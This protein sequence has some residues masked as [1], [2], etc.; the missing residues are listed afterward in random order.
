MNAPILAPSVKPLI[1]SFIKS[2]SNSL[3]LN[4]P[5]GAGK[6]STAEYLLSVL[7]ESNDI[8]KNPYIKI[9]DCEN[10]RGIDDIRL[11]QKDLTNKPLGNAEFKRG[12]ILNNFEN[13]SVEAQN[14]ALKLLE[15]PPLDTIFI[16]TT[17]S[18]ST[19]LPTIVS[20]LQ[21]I[22][23]KPIPREDLFKFFP[24]YKES[25]LESAYL[26]TEGYSERFSDFIKNPQNEDKKYI[27]QAKTILKDSKT[28][29]IKSIDKILKSDDFEIR[30][31]L[32]ALETILGAIL[33]GQINRT[34][35]VDLR[36]VN[37]LDQIINSKQ[38]LAYNPNKKL[39]LTNLLYKI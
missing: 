32:K 13:L 16:V 12:I 15:E 20:R 34:N 5:N 31:L 18:K 27:D 25:E 24:S 36:I 38:S 39:L 29:R 10:S 22:N 11:I 28:A 9:I 35:E 17:N 21:W 2:P 14:S 1:D 37:S 33:R 19:I 3:G 30:K 23:L 8:Y 4:A 7:L 26:A 6:K